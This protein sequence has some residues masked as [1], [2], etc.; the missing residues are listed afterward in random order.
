MVDCYHAKKS[1]P[2]LYTEIFFGKTQITEM[3]SSYL[4]YNSG[5]S[6]TIY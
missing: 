1:I 6:F 4:L 2:R 5:L 3:E